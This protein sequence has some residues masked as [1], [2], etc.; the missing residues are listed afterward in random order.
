[1]SIIEPA[2][3]PNSFT[4][5]KMFVN[6]IKP[7][8]IAESFE[9]KAGDFFNQLTPINPKPDVFLFIDVCRYIDSN[10]IKGYENQMKEMKHHCLFAKY[11]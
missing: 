1:M 7:N 2:P 8:T 10:E 11:D 9:M 4:H 3:N 5:F 6:W